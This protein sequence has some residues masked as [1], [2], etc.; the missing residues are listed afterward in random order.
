MSRRFLAPLVLVGSVALAAGFAPTVASADSAAGHDTAAHAT[1]TTSTTTTTSA[2]ARS[3]SVPS[4]QSAGVRKLRAPATKSHYARTGAASSATT[5]NPSLAVEFN[6]GGIS[7]F[8]ITV[9]ADV[10]G[11]DTTTSGGLSATLDWGDGT[12]SNYSSITTT[13]TFSHEYNSTGVYSL[14][15]TVSDGAGDSATTTWSGLE[16]EGAEYTPY[17]PTRVLDTRSG[18]GAPASPV[19]AGGVV[20][21]QVGNAPIPEPY[22]IAAVVLNVTVTQATSNGFLTVYGDQDI[23]GTPVPTPQTSNL[24]FAAGQTVPNLVIVPV[25]LNGVVDFANGAPKGSVQVVADVEGYFSVTET[26]KF[27]NITPTRILD[28]RNGTGSGAV[29][30]IPANGDLTLTVAGAGKGAI[31]AGGASAVA[32]N[33]TV[34]DSTRAGFITAYPAGQSLPNAS[35]VNY[36]PGQIVANSSIVPV[37]T[38]GQI[39]FHNSSSGPVDLIADA[40]GYFTTAQV[41]GGNAFVPA[42]TPTRDLDTRP[43][44]LQSGTPDPF[45]VGFSTWET[46]IVYNAT[47]TNATGNGFLSLY[48]YD[49]NTPNVLPSTSN[50]NYGVNQ[51]VPNLA[52]VPIGTV[53]DTA[54]N[55]GAN[56]IGIYLGGHG[57]A[58][59]ILDD[60][61]FFANS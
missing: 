10:T 22:G 47:V 52:I 28:T 53:L 27:M 46:S 29:K 2:T 56:E 55:P 60:F 3:A 33:L 34:A 11:Y 1:S 14:T 44:P 40:S 30:Q 4:I 12:T 37:G 58:N 38:N 31:P 23:G 50:L 32:M 42:S 35:N 48:P 43:N 41:S 19:A 5:P 15:L 13:P 9:N 57:S 54:Y 6:T 7:A 59:V 51:T 21:L 25:G 16:T 45:V 61:G 36:G 24:N 20:Q 8:G 18:T 17:T 49:P 26:A 39:V